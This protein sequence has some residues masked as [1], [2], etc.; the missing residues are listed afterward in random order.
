[1][2]LQAEY[3][4]ACSWNVP[5]QGYVLLF[6][7]LSWVIPMCQL[8]NKTT[9]KHSHTQHH[10]VLCISTLHHYYVHALVHYDMFRFDWTVIRQMYVAI[11]H[12]SSCMQRKRFFSEIWFWNLLSTRMSIPRWR[13]WR[14]ISTGTQINFQQQPC[15]YQRENIL[16]NLFD[17]HFTSWCKCIVQATRLRF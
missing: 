4:L 12:K 17:K 9:I 2:H 7:N 14:E 16:A 13:P 5:C 8:S 3:F 15:T 6:L 1:V 11:K 10:H